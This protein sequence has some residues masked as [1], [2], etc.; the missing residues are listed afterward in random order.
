MN[1]ASEKV[2]D[3]KEQTHEKIKKAA[4]FADNI[5]D[6]VGDKTESLK[7]QFEDCSQTFTDNIR[8]FPVR[9]VL[10]AGLAGFFT[11]MLLKK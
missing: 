8:E 7:N 10:L 6:K 3:F 4:D 2:S 1:L 11:A 9:S 5:V